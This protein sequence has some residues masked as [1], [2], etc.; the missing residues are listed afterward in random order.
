MDK[1]TL[2]GI[3]ASLFAAQVYAAEH[4]IEE[5]VVTG[6]FHEPVTESA[7]PVS[8]LSGEAL[9]KQVA[10]SLG[11]T[12]DGQ[13]G[14]HS[15]SFGTGVGQPVLRGQ[16]GK[17]VQVLQNSVFIADAANV[18]PDHANGIE[19]LL[20]DSIEVVR[21][22]ATLLYGSGAIGGVVNVIDQRVPSRLFEKPEIVLEQS[23][24]SVN[25][26]NRTI[27]GVTA[28][29]GSFGVHFDAY[30]R[31]SENV[32]VPGFAADEEAIEAL[33]EL[34]GA[35]HEEEEEEASAIENYIANSDAEA[36]GG[37]FG[38]SWVQ[39]NG[40]IG[41]SYNRFESEY[42]LPPGVHGHHHHE[43]EEHDEDHGDD[44]HDEEDHEGEAH[45]E[46][47][48]QIR[49]ALDQERYDF[50]GDY[51]FDSGL[52][53]KAA[54]H[55][56]FTDYEHVELEIEDGVAA[57]G[58]RFQND[59]YDS[60]FTLT[61]RERGNWQGVWGVQINSSDF[62]AIGEEAFIPETDTS[63]AAVFVVERLVQAEQTFEFAAR[64]ERAGLE[65]GRCDQD[66]TVFSVSASMLK[67]LGGSRQLTLGLGRSERAA[68]IEERFSNVD[69][70][71]CGTTA[72]LVTHA[73]TNLIEIGNANLDTE[74]S[75]NFDIGYRFNVGSATA[76]VTAFYNDFSDYVF[77]NLTGQEVDE[78][79]VA[80]YLGADAEFYGLEAM[81]EFPLFANGAYG[82]SG[83]VM[84]DIVRAEFSNGDNVPRVPPARIGFG[85][86]WSSAKWTAEF[87][88]TR[89]FEQ[90]R[91]APLE[92]PTAGYTM[93]NLYADYHWMMANEVDIALF[94]RAENLLDREVRNHVS[95]L[96]NNAPEPGRAIR[97]GVRITF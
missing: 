11:E 39:D 63:N 20:A 82:V 59:G 90:D 79:Q 44:D 86:N 52:F 48:E 64:L 94:A 8:V 27:V 92:L 84:T 57:V 43:D 67:D 78:V 34:T 21:G 3:V 2:A 72:E 6:P 16:S 80:T 32:N 1:C 61:T 30:D 31:R 70:A 97:A 42:G 29:L 65:S 28:S 38:V 88:V 83:F 68:T 54:F 62:S 5:I 53:T 18:S 51:H 85:V 19:P 14:V 91:S 95:F 7:L 4:E 41:F 24:N 9:R 22:P 55:I 50:K 12:L 87:D 37:T 96:K 93:V 47:D 74:T 46:E 77:L 33:E 25:D 76:E 45:G 35:E 15:S 49:L 10:N 26:E 66:D 69:T 36:T 60:R 73:A 23:H 81:L 75:L 89:V 17:R 13:P 58:T 40:Y 71:T 56:G